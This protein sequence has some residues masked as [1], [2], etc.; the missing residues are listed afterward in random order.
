M[1]PAIRQRALLTYSYLAVRRTSLSVAKAD[2]EE[3]RT[4]KS[5]V[6]WQAAEFVQC[7]IQIEQ[8]HGPIADAVRASCTL[9]MMAGPT[10]IDGRRYVDGCVIDN[11]PVGALREEE[12]VH[13][14]AEENPRA[15][16]QTLF[17]TV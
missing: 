5:V 9:P 2:A 13:S 6:L 12:C 17:V 4:R 14:D 15:R 16:F 7:W 10:V 11:V 3:R 8:T 1:S